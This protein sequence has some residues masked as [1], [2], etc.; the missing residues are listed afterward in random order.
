[1]KITFDPTLTVQWFVSV[2]IYI[3]VTVIGAL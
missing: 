3:F 2:G 1:M